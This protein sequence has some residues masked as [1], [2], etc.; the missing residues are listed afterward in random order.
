MSFVTELN[1]ARQ[2]AGMQPLSEEQV[3]KLTEAEGIFV[4]FGVGFDVIDDDGDDKSGKVT[5]QV[6]CA[7]EAEAQRV[8]AVL[9]KNEDSFGD[10]YDDWLSHMAQNAYGGDYSPGSG[11]ISG[12]PK[13]VKKAKDGRKIFGTPA[14]SFL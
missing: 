10:K 4:E 1:R 13:I 14:S 11:Y 8:I 3:T 12:D 2:L 7:D 9:K 6:K 5:A